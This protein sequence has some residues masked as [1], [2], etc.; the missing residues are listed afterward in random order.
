MLPP[1]LLRLFGDGYRVFFLG[2]A[3]F[4]ILALVL[5]LLWLQTGLGLPVSPAHWHEHEMVFGY[6]TAALA[7]FFLTAV[8]NW[9]GA[10]AARAG[11]IGGA[12]LIW[13]LGRAA[14]WGAGALPAMLVATIDLAFLPILG[15]KI[16]AQ[17]VKRPKPQNLLFLLVLTLIWV[18][19][20]RVHLDWMDLP[21]GDASAGIRAGLV[22][23]CAMIAILGGRVTPAF[24]RNAMR[25]VDETLPGPR[26]PLPLT[27]LANVG[28]GL[29]AVA[30]LFSAPPAL[31]GVLA[32]VAGASQLVRL[33]LWRGAWTFSRPILWSMHLSYGFLGLGFL[34]YGLA[35]FGYGAEVAALHL[36]GIGAVGGMT[37]AI[38]GRAILGHSGRALIAPRPLV[39]AYGAM[40]LA[41]VLR[42]AAAGVFMSHAAG[43]NLVA[44]SL[45]IIALGLFL[46]ALWRAIWDPRLPRG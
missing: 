7:G 43:L 4:G 35:Q 25:K 40:A 8:P 11:F 23:I 32:T 18:A 45:W 16:A 41:A 22:G 31:V 34:A 26:T 2:A 3:L 27:L 44:G 19:N 39:F 28:A 15:W 36:L 29:A 24:T 12:A 5:W 33:S 30:L 17:L 10:P 21:W 1:S 37:L 42:F 9:T 20:L 6:G 13:L 38:M 14:I 46:A